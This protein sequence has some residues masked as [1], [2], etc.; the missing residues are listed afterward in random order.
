MA[1]HKRDKS[2]RLVEFCHDEKKLIAD[3]ATYIGGKGYDKTND[4]ICQMRK[5]GHVIHRISDGKNVWIQ[6]ISGP[7]TKPSMREDIEKILLNGEQ[8]TNHELAEL[9]DADLE[10]I[11]QCMYKLERM[12]YIIERKQ[13]NYRTWGY[14]MTGRKAK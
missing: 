10:Q 11:R 9:M 6:H 5:H 3:V 7:E 12:G 8:W 4:I 2:L 14:A 1:Y 13:I